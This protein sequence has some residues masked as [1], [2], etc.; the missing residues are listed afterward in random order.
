MEK[1]NLFRI[2]LFR[3]LQE[4]AKENGMIPID[5]K[6]S[7]ERLKTLN[8]NY[9]DMEMAYIEAIKAGNTIFNFDNYENKLF[10]EGR[11]KHGNTNWR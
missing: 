8:K 7:N 10:Q 1:L 5:I 9:S 4:Y 3:R 2:L 11:L 6:L